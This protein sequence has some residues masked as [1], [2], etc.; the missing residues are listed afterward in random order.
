MNKL[1]ELHIPNT[2]VQSSVVPIHWC[3]HPKVLNWLK[4]NS[5]TEPLLLIVTYPEGGADHH[6]ECRTLV[7]LKNMMTYIDFRRSGKNNIFAAIL[8]NI[9]SKEF[10]KKIPLSGFNGFNSYYDEYRLTSEFES[11]GSYPKWIDKCSAVDLPETYRSTESVYDNETE[12]FIGG[13]DKPHA[14]TDIINADL[15][16]GVFAKPPPKWEQTWVNFFFR[17]KEHDQCEFRRRRL[18]AYTIQPILL[19]LL[20]LIRCFLAILF[21]SVGIYVKKPSVIF[22]PINYSMDDI[23]LGVWA[24][25]PGKPF[26]NGDDSR[27]IVNLMILIMVMPLA[28]IIEILAGYPGIGRMVIAGIVLMIGLFVL[29]CKIPFIAWIDKKLSPSWKRDESL[30]YLVC[31]P[32]KQYFNIK[33]LPKSRRT[34]KLRLENIKARVCRPYSR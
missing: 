32:E 8:F 27:T 16:E 17:E 2:N 12:K 4:E 22:N 15:P 25:I 3:V 13:E 7:P 26:D 20:I 11:N 9:N 28:W 24:K 21:L 29:I 18:L 10:I 6:L 1:L 19:L 5:E 23:I 30:Q 31:D 34:F 14:I 33:D